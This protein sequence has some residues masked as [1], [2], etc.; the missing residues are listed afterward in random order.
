MST[1]RKLLVALAVFLLV[2]GG[3][4]YWIWR[5]TPA[6]HTLAELSGRDPVL[7][8]PKEEKIPSISIAKPIGWGAGEAPVA[9]R[10]LLVTRFAD[11]LDHARVLYVLPNGDV[12]A[13][14]ADAPKNSMGGGITAA[15]GNFI[16]KRAGAHVASPDALV[17]LRDADGDG[18]A[19]QR[20]VL[21]QGNGL[22]SPS[23]MAWH[24]D[25]LY[26]AN[27]N[28]V[29][30]F[31]YKLGETALAGQPSKV[32][33]LPGGGNH[34]MRNLV[35]SPDGKRLYAAVGSSSNIGENGMKLDK[36]ARRS[37]KRNSARPITRAS[38]PKG[39]AIPTGW[40]GTRPA[41]TCG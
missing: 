38:S 25:I 29:L 28:G 14:E 36:A 10:G 8:E 7:V 30:A 21:R 17:L 32:M 5:G 11:G 27:H 26:V 18:K 12:L 20:F 33:D 3:L 16:M 41:A 31:P 35:L 34:W 37:G 15:I 22:I 4:F 6:Q 2:F 39:C 9:A 13:A 23:G 40:T 19:D 24:N 1:K